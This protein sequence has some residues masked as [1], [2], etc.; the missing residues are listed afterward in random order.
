MQSVN[1]F[2]TWEPYGTFGLGVIATVDSESPQGGIQTTRMT[3]TMAV[4]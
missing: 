2:D 4:P 1:M 3:I